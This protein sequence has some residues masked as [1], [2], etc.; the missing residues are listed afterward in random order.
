ME[1]NESVCVAKFVCRLESFQKKKIALRK[2]KI[3]PGI[4]V[5]SKLFFVADTRTFLSFEK[6]TEEV[7]CVLPFYCL[8]DVPS[9]FLSFGR[10]VTK[11][12]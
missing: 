6:S 8:N 4:D 10:F 12:C 9:L 7:K 3:V 5:K 2:D 1:V 11:R